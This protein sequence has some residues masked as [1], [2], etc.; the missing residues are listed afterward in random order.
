MPQV[1]MMKTSKGTKPV[2]SCDH[3][4]IKWFIF[5][6][7]LIPEDFSSNNIERQPARYFVT[8]FEAKN[9]PPK[10][11]GVMASMKKAFVGDAPKEFVDPFVQV[12]FAGKT[13]PI[14]LITLIEY[15]H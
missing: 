8:I 12:S 15:M 11:S 13:V 4:R 3:T 10:T 9:L 14:S 7:L 6:N 2:T 1:K 5:R